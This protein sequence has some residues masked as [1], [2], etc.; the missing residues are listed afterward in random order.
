MKIAR[1]LKSKRVKGG[2]LELESVEVQVQLTETKSVEDLTPKDVIY[3]LSVYM[4][5][6]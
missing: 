6:D 4:H 5:H 1:H 2:A 3:L